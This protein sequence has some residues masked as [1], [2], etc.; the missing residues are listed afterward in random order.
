MDF[1]YAVVRS[2]LVLPEDCRRRLS[3]HIEILH[4][5]CRSNIEE[6]D[7][8]FGIDPPG[9]PHDAFHAANGGITVSIVD[10]ELN[11]QEIDAGVEFRPGR[12]RIPSRFHPPPPVSPR[13]CRSRRAF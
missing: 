11:D 4:E 5:W 12:P 9:V 2:D 8:R 10:R 3:F 13:T 1:G 7:R 6:Y